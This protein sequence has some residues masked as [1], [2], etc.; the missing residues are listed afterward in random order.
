MY[1]TIASRVTIWHV[2]ASFV[3]SIVGLVGGFTWFTLWLSL[4]L[5]FL[6][7]VADFCWY[8]WSRY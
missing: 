4:G 8:R 1:K 7:W 2:A 3:G 6:W 5:M